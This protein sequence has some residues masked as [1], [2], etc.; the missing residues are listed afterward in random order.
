L[1]ASQVIKNA[2]YLATALHGSATLPFVI[3]TGA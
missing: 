2:L 1:R 3:S